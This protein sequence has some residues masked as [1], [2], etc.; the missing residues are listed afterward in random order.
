VRVRNHGALA[1]CPDKAPGGRK[2][3]FVGGD[4]VRG[5]WPPGVLGWL[6]YFSDHVLHGF[7]RPVDWRGMKLLEDT[8]HGFPIFANGSG[9]VLFGDELDVFKLIA[10]GR[11]NS[12][13]ATELRLNVKAVVH[14]RRR[15]VE[16]L[17]VE[18]TE[19]F[20]AIA[21]EHGLK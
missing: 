18:R 11:Q 21:A 20:A 6:A 19:E 7:A 14:V 8:G 2:G 4:S 1:E 12:E 15:L 17:G 10:Q 16:C 13:I 3:R 5:N 9:L